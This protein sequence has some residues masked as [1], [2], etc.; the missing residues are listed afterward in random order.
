MFGVIIWLGLSIGVGA[1]AASKGRSGI[2]FFILS[3]LLSP[4]IGLIVALVVSPVT[5]KVE[6][7]A[8]E[9]GEHK[10]CPKCAELVKSEAIV[11]KHCQAD[12]A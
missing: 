2:G 6:A 10:K 7:A 11:C 5:A 1:F 9:S 4:L 3:L 12:L 8:I